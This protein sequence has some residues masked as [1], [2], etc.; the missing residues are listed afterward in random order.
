MICIYDSRGNEA[1]SLRDFIKRQPI[2]IQ[3]DMFTNLVET[4][5]ANGMLTLDDIS[6]IIG[7]SVYDTDETL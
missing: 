7:E 5:Y 3:A 6:T 1:L 4:L 2:Q